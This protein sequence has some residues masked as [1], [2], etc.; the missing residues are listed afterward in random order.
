MNAIVR[1][2]LVSFV[3]LTALTGIAYPLLV[4]G[5]S[6]VAFA[7]QAAGSLLQRD[8]KPSARR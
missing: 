2:A 5:I 7:D 8:G 4:T 3:V 1:P 6:Q